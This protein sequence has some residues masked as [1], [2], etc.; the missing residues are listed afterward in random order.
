MASLGVSLGA[1]FGVRSHRFLLEGLYAVGVDPGGFLPTELR[2]VVL[3]ILSAQEVRPQ[4][5]YVGLISVV[6]EDVLEFYC[7]IGSE[8]DEFSTVP[9]L[10]SLAH[11]IQIHLR[12]ACAAVL[13]EDSEHLLD[14]LTV[15]WVPNAFNVH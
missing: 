13:P 12:G 8:S 14:L 11:A 4:P 9:C 1:C 2:R 5:T 7:F 3:E 10:C 6:V 15:H